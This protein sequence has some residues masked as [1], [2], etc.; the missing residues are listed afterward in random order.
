M[1]NSA[2]ASTDPIVVRDVVRNEGVPRPVRRA[3]TI[4]E[5][6]VA[7]IESCRRPPDDGG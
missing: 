2:L 6:I 7:Y 4:E 1:I 5:F 3:L